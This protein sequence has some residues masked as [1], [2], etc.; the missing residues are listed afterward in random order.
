ME[1]Q[2]DDISEKVAA[3]A[4]QGPTSGQLLKVAAEADI[5]NL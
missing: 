2:V 1:V 3:L 4:L 5:T